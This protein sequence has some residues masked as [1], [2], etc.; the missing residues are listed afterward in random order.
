[1]QITING[2]LKSFDYDRMTIAELVA[3]MNLTGKRIAIEC[4][5]EIIARS[6][7][8]FTQLSQDDALEIVGAVGGG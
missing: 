4:N 5:G 2:H 8:E 1:M 3:H 7:Y 6:Q